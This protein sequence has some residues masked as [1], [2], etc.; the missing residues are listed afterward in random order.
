MGTIDDA[1]RAKAE[2]EAETARTQAETAENDRLKAIADREAAEIARDKAR[3]ELAE[4]QAGAAARTR[5]TDLAAEASRLDNVAKLQTAVGAATPELTGVKTGELHIPAD[6]VMFT[7]LLSAR[8]LADAADR[9]RAAVLGKQD[10]CRVIVTA[11]PHLLERDA[12]RLGIQARLADLTAVIGSFPGPAVHR[13]APS[14]SLVETAVIGAATAAAKLIPGVLSLLAA[15]RTLTAVDVTV[16]AENAVIAVAGSIAE[17]KPD[18]EVVIDAFRVLA[19]GDAP[20]EGSVLAARNALQ[21]AVVQL[22]MQIA[23]QNAAAKEDQDADWLAAAAGLTAN[24]REVLAA[25]DTIPAG[26]TMS[27][28]TAAMAVERLRFG[29][30]DGVVLVRVVGASASELTS[31]RASFLKDRIHAS[32]SVALSYAFIARGSSRV[33]AAGVVTGSS[34]LVGTIGAQIDVTAYP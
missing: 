26:A 34:Q 20:A 31:D 29:A 16:D 9:V 14:R 32:A 33:R 2:A 8:A 5:T 22:Q 28:L 7:T 4:W 17:A 27:P 23:E 24:G 1:Q 19:D 12:A 13:D 11:D 15:N 10:D 30:H 18:S 6:K 21:A 3:A 25:I